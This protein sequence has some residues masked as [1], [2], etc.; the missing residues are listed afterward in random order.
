MHLCS[1]LHGSHIIQ[2][3]LVQML[4]H[5]EDYWNTSEDPPLTSLEAGE[6]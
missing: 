5:S 3:D 6:E 4:W 1:H 2:L